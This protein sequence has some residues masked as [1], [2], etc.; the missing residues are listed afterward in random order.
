MLRKVSGG[1]PAAEEPGSNESGLEASAASMVQ[2]RKDS[3]QDETSRHRTT[4]ASST[5]HSLISATDIPASLMHIGQHCS[6]LNSTR[7]AILLFRS[8]Y[9][10]VT[11]KYNK[12]TWLDHSLRGLCT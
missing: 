9:S 2:Q 4:L 7:V 12:K 1:L 11:I 3:G 6:K 5:I 10:D 8:V